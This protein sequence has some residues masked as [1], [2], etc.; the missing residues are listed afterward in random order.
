MAS[1]GYTAVSPNAGGPL[2]TTRVYAF[3]TTS[4]VGHYARNRNATLVLRNDLI[5]AK[6]GRWEIFNHSNAN[7]YKPLPGGYGPLV[8]GYVK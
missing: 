4:S 2:R 8:R 6:W 1:L 5:R 3:G 7:P